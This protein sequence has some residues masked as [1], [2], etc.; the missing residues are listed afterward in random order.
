[1]KACDLTYM[2]WAK[3]HQPARF[4]L[5][6]SG[7][8]AASLGDFDGLAEPISLETEGPYGRPDLIQ[9]LARLREVDP[10][11]ILPTTGASSANLIALACVARRGDRVLL[12]TPV[13]DPLPRAAC[14]LGLHPVFFPRHAQ[15]RFCPDFAAIQ[16]GLADG[17]KAVFITNL[18][19]PSGLQCRPADLQALADAT[20]EHDAFLIVDEV[21]LDYAHLESRADRPLAARLGEHVITTDSLTKVYGLGGL[22]AGWIIARPEFIGRAT[23][24]VDLLNVNDSV[25][26][27]QIATRA[28]A[29]IDALA[30][31]TRRL[32]GQTYPIFSSWLRSRPD[33]SSPGNDGALFSWVRLP[34]GITAECLCETLASRFETNLVSGSFFG[35]S[36]HVRIGFGLPAE[37]LREGLSRVGQAIDELTKQGD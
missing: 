25:V 24:V 34:G 22:R 32:H 26:S 10:A 23:G 19:N 4:E 1:M 14:F 6:A 8:P 15:G 7:V 21:Y 31:R 16:R 2:A 27:A 28:L 3:T 37:D 12:E 36:R 11:W 35:S 17:A 29:S 5:T 33:L 13:Y 20:A 30:R 18:H 9:A